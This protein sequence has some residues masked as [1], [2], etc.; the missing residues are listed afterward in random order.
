MFALP[1]SHAL[2]LSSTVLHTQLGA[3]LASSPSTITGPAIPLQRHGVMAWNVGPPTAFWWN[4]TQ[5]MMIYEAARYCAGNDTYWPPSEGGAL[6]PY[7][8]HSYFRIRD[9]LSGEVVGNVQGSECFA[10]GSAV[11]DP[12]L[13]RAWVF[14]SERDLCGGKNK[15]TS[16]A[17]APFWQGRTAE[18]NGVRAW[19]SDDLVQWHTAQQPALSYPAYPFNTDVTP[20]VNKSLLT[21]ADGSHTIVDTGSLEAATGDAEPLNF[22]LV[23]E[24]GRVATH[25]APDR[26]LS[27]GW[28]HFS[29]EHHEASRGFGACPAVHYGEEDGF[30]YVISGGTEISLA[31]TL[32]L[33]HWEHTDPLVRTPDPWSGD[34][35]R[36][37]NVQL[38]EFLG[39]REQASGN[40]PRT[41]EHKQ[42]AASMNS[43]LAN[44]QCWE[45]DVNDSDM[46]CGGPLT[47]P[48]APQD[49]AWV[50]FSPSSQGSP[51]HSN[52]STI[53]PQLEKTNFN[54]AQKLPSHRFGYIC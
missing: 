3:L 32:D 16:M 28:V 39:M 31:R 14:G 29:G 33:K 54:G 52:C 5:R 50:L 20:V 17:C 46:C 47:A 30:F 49:R 8:L 42:A 40:F 25:T 10:Y 24:S 36:D 11:V 15:T 4:K 19:W 38:S 43:S 51:P 2:L 27:T 23:S 48:G 6:Q 13:Q 1:V 34:N 44:P 9:M 41:A 35:F 53:T 37:A 26:N 12:T 18:G 21:H 45:K 22:V 7:S